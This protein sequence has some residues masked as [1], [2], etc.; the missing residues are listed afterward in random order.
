MLLKCCRCQ[1]WRQV[2]V[3]PYSGL[4]LPRLRSA[5][6]NP[7]P[8]VP[9]RILLTDSVPFHWIT[10]ITLMGNCNFFYIFFYCSTQTEQ[11]LMSVRA[12]RSSPFPSVVMTGSLVLTTWD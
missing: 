9:T 12:R 10:V 8:S 11:C 3:S 5:V 7:Q 6:R 4:L 1:R 2:G